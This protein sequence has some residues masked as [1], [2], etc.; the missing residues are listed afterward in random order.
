MSRPKLTT[1]K[2]RLSA[3]PTK[4]TSIPGAERMRGRAAV[5]RRHRWLSLHPLCAE[6]ERDGRATEAAVVDHVI[7]LWNGGADDY[8]TNGQSLCNPHHDAKTTREAAERARGG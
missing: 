3:L 8:E 6:C 2:P 5:D 1:L 4:L 7:P